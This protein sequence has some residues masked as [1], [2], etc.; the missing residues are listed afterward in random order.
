MSNSKVMIMQD[1]QAI[2]AT[3]VM[4]ELWDLEA[5]EQLLKTKYFHRELPAMKRSLEEMIAIAKHNGGFIEV[6]Y[7][8][9]G[10]NTSCAGRYKTQV[11]N[12]SKLTNQICFVAM[13]RE[14][15]AYIAKKNYLDIDMVNC[16]PIIIKQLNAGWGVKAETFDYYVDNRDQCLLEIM[17]MGCSKEIA[18]ELIL[19][20]TFGGTIEE[21]CSEY[22]KPIDDLPE[23]VFKLK[24]EISFMID[25]YSSQMAFQHI[26]KYAEERKL[27]NPKKRC[28]KTS[29][30]SYIVQGYERMIID[31]LIAIVESEGHTVGSIIYDGI[32]IQMCDI[33]ESDLQRW[34]D[35][36]FDVCQFRIKLSVKPFEISPLMHSRLSWTAWERL[37]FF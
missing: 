23:F 34:C 25:F 31:H 13:K 9:N 17:D 15:R 12:G 3:R 6:E 20:L 22:E 29:T 32:H 33:V 27:A 1:V 10:Y 4:K 14:F 18:K 7:G 37:L 19:R 24:E 26:R 11:R 16:H 8:F 35:K 21:W 30:F 5:C 36:V 28:V 2:R